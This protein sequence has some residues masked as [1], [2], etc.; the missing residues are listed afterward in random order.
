MN[1]KYVMNRTKTI[2]Y[3]HKHFATLL[4]NNM[5]LARYDIEKEE[6]ERL[7]VSNPLSNEK[8]I[9]LANF[10]KA[11]SFIENDLKTD[12]L[13]LTTL[14]Q[15]LMNGLNENCKS[16]LNTEQIDELEKMINQPAKANTE[17]AIDVCLYI[18]EKRLFSDGDVRVALLFANKIMVDNGNGLISIAPH[19]DD[20]FRHNLK[21]FHEG[22]NDFKNWL[23][24]Y[25][26][27]GEKYDY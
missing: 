24:R 8:E 3:L 17:I 19:H 18:L 13:T 4:Y 9:A 5:K 2:N 10:I 27:I 21:A 25:G 14:H 20:E 7:I 26:V 22:E 1:N 15:I 23:Y 12:Y 11:Y 6:V 16:E